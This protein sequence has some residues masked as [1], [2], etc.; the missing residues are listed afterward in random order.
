MQLYEQDGLSFKKGDFP[1]QSLLLMMKRLTKNDFQ[2]DP[3]VIECSWARLVLLQFILEILG[4]VDPGRIE[5]QYDYADKGLKRDDDHW[6]ILFL[7]SNSRNF[8]I[9]NQWKLFSEGGKTSMCQT[10]K[11]VT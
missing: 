1:L 9:S 3:A 4:M 7:T 5:W 6:R 8:N 2:S 10:Q 11:I